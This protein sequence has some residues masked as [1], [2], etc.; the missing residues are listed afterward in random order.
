METAPQPPKGGLRVSPARRLF[1]ELCAILAADPF[2]KGRS[3]LLCWSGAVDDAKDLSPTQSR[4]AIRLTPGVGPVA[5]WGPNQRLGN[6]EVTVE[7]A[8][9]TSD[10]DVYLDLFY[11][12]A[13]AFCPPDDPARADAIAAR[14]RA[15]GAACPEVEWAFPPDLPAAARTGGGKLTFTGMFRIP[16]TF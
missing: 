12:L 2:L 6:L 9:A 5:W 4:P 3:T 13:A 10:G 14:L 7:V 11:T 8:V 16:T 15:A 1:R